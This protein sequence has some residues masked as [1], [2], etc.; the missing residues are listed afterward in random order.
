MNL[1]DQIV[2]LIRTWVPILIGVALTKLGLML[3]V[4]DLGV[5][6]A[7]LGAAMAGL[8]TAVYYAIARKAEAR[9]PAAGILLGFRKAPSY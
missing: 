4:D 9:W 7:S 8:V 2:S 5:D 1:S 6:G 3:G